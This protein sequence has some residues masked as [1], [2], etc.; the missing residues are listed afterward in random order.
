MEHGHLYIIL[1][2][3]FGFFM[4]WGVGANDVANAMG[5][6]VGSRAL[7]ITQ[8]IIIAAIFEAAGSLLAG[9]QVTDTIR[10]KIID[11]ALFANS[12][13][14]LIDGMWASLL[15][16][17]TWLL[18]A[19]RFGWPVSTTH[20]IVGAVIGFG[21]IGLGPQ[22]IYWGQTINIAL[23]WV[24][25]PVIAGV[26]AFA[27]FRSVQTFIFNSKKPIHS[28]KLLVPFYIFLV[29]LVISLVT[30]LFRSKT[31]GVRLKLL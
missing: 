25:T 6:S 17:G 3:V 10:S 4:A 24:V 28:A 12:P 26:I 8:A 20:S 1:A 21:V 31:R 9:G 14:L 5:T 7:T 15:A 22:A 23:S 16:A 18:I 27:L 11:A 30:F 13:Q 2:A 19:T 29:A